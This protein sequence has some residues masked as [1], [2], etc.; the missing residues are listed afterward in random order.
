MSK[1]KVAL[2]NAAGEFCTLADY[3]KENPCATVRPVYSLGDAASAIPEMLEELNKLHRLVEVISAFGL[4]RDDTVRVGG[5]VR[6]NAK[7]MYISD[8]SRLYDIL[9]KAKCAVQEAIA[10]ADKWRATHYEVQ[11]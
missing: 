6:I 5:G 11:D 3:C 10:M 4:V 1:R 8:G 2:R 7:G 9:E